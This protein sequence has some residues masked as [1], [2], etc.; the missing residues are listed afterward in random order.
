[1]QLEIRLIPRENWEADQRGVL[2]DYWN[3]VFQRLG[4]EAYWADI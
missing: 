1:V 4:V 2:F 3:A